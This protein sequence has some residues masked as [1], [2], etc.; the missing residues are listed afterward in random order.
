MKKRTIEVFVAGCPICDETVKL[1]KSIVCPS[2]N[3]QVLNLSNDSAAQALAHKYGIKRVP[4]VV[5]DGKLADCCSSGAVDKNIL[6]SMGVGR[7]L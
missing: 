6:Q 2:C 7:Q 4:A 5:V 1:V 3:L